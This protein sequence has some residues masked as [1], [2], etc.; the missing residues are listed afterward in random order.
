[1]LLIMPDTSPTYPDSDTSIEDT[2][3]PPILIAKFCHCTVAH[4]P[5]QALRGVTSHLVT[6]M[7]MYSHPIVGVIPHDC[8]RPM[9]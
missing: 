9:V 6:D 1:M 3:T 4:G 5:K 2:R 8:G 7:C